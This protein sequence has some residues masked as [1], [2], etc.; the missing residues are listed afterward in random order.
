MEK[1]T[2]FVYQIVSLKHPRFIY[3]A[4]KSYKTSKMETLG[5][6]LD[7]WLGEERLNA[8]MNAEG[9]LTIELLQGLIGE[10]ADIRLVHIDNDEYDHPFCHIQAIYPPGTLVADEPDNKDEPSQK[11][12]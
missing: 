6:D 7:S 10:H 11:A 3:L 4:G 2:R 8:M 9:G 12:A 5:E 1:I